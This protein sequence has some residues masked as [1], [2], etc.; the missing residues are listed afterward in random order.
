M[1]VYF[2]GTGNS[3]YVSDMIADIIGDEVLSSSDYIKQGI[4]AELSS[5][6]PWVFV[7]PVY[8]NSPAAIFEDFIKKA[9]FSGSRKAYFIMTAASEMGASPS[10]CKKLAEKK[11]F[12]Y[13]GCA[14][15]EMPQNYLLYFRMNTDEKIE[16]IVKSAEEKIRSL[17]SVIACGKSFDEKKKKIGEYTMTVSVRWLFN[18]RFTSPKKF[19]ASEKCIGC[20]KCAALCPLG[21]IRMKNGSPEWGKKCVHCVSCINL[22]PAK[23]IEFGK[24]T[25]GKMRYSCPVYKSKNGAGNT[26]SDSEKV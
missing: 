15:V 19:R 9:T 7:C 8:V 17:T 24:R 4:A 18:K 6:S 3:R 10:F 23:A 16:K 5:S 22:C 14:L 11:G 13:M 2:S 21:N 12:E 20:G 25:V 1:V 26:S